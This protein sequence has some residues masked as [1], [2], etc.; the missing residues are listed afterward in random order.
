MRKKVKLEKKSTAGFTKFWDMHSGGGC[1]L[2]WEIIIINRSEEEACKIF[3]Q[4]FDRDPT[5]TTC[6][7]CGPDYAIDSEE[8]LEKLLSFHLSHVQKYKGKTLEEMLESPDVLYI[9]VEE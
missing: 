4:Q 1:K 8:T 3:E 9:E 5:H 6:E 7:C 2:D